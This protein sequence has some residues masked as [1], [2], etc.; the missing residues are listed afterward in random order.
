MKEF[1]KK[2]PVSRRFVSNLIFILILFFLAYVYHNYYY[3]NARFHFPSKKQYTVKVAEKGIIKFVSGRQLEIKNDLSVTE[4]ITRNDSEITIQGKIDGQLDPVLVPLFN[5]SKYLTEIDL[6]DIESACSTNF[7]PLYPVG[8]RRL[9]FF[10]PDS[11]LFD[12]QKW[13]IN[14]CKRKLNCS[15]T[16][17]I[18]E[19]RTNVDMLCSG[20]IQESEIA[21]TGHLAVNSKRNG[22]DSVFLDITSSN[23]ELVSSWTFEDSL[24]R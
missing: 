13:E 24:I 21:M 11:A 8:L 5:S 10:M 15:Y 1:L 3:V 7:N 6:S 23:S 18:V 2:I 17:S 19:E 22:F 16:L 4:N 14:T 9:I 20:L 12:K